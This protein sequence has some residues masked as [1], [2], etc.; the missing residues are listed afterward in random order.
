MKN[1]IV[2]SRYAKSLMGLAMEKGNLEQ[3]KDD[4]KLIVETCKNSREFRIFITNP[5]IKSDKK[6]A[7]FDQI[8][9]T[10]ISDISSQFI[11]LLAKKKRE[12]YLESIS[13]EFLKQY[14]EHKQI[15]TA[16]VTTAAGLDSNLKQKVL[17]MV[18]DSTKWEVELVEKIDPSIIGGFILEYSDKRVDTAISHKLNKLRREFKENPYIKNF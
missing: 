4:M 16:V 1:T 10:S 11:K 12:I 2:A 18:I 14:N 3:V 9:G 17:Q 7:I 8:L 6:T 5:I 13:K 15:M